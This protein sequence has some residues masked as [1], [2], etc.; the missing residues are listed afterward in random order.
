MEIK[1]WEEDS[2]GG[3]GVPV[4]QGL[5]LLLLPM[6][7]AATLKPDASRYSELGRECT[8]FAQ[9]LGL[10]LKF[11]F[12]TPLPRHLRPLAIS[13]VMPEGGF[14]DFRLISNLIVWTVCLF[15]CNQKAKWKRD[16]QSPFCLSAYFKI[17]PAFKFLVCQSPF[18][19]FSVSVQTTKQLW[20]QM[21]PNT[22]N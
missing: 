11:Y 19:P 20:Y 4:D 15:H 13:W 12:N 21:P 6:T 18:S 14:G 10:E 5:L 17:K 16:F 1:W 8:R 3:R 7:Y 2:A 22:V 9:G